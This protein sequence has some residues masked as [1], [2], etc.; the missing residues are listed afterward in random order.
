M[1]QFLRLDDGIGPSIEC[2]RSYV[3]GPTKHISYWKLQGPGFD[4][5]G[6]LSIDTSADKKEGS[7][8]LSVVGKLIRG[9]LLGSDG[10]W[11]SPAQKEASTTFVDEMVRSRKVR[12]IVWILPFL[13]FFAFIWL[14]P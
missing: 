8:S 3:E 5:S 13:Q 2:P 6:E 4:S 12:Q 11:G 1:P 9:G 14:S 7:L 10:D